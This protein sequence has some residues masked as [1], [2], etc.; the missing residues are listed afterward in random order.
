MKYRNILTYAFLILAIGI[1]AANAQTVTGTL[2]DATVAR[3]TTAKGTIVLTIPAGLHVNS[4]KPNS[5][6]A[7][8]TKVTI[9]GVGFKPGA[10]EYPEGTNRKFQF[11]ESELN[12]YEGE[13]AIPF[14]IV[15]PRGFRGDAL[16]V[17]AVVRYQACTEEICYPPKN[18]TITIVAAVK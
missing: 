12:V 15:V 3:G 16:S 7:I 9:S 13:I 5:E 6:Y 14:S 2:T 18:K 8:A 4:N 1:T 10:I 17:K 11:S